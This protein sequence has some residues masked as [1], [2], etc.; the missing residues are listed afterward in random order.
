MFTELACLV[1]PGMRPI[2][3]VGIWSFKALAQSDAYSKGF[4]DNNE[5]ISTFLD[6]LVLEFLA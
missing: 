6:L 5:V 2:R 3:E 4:V 1:R